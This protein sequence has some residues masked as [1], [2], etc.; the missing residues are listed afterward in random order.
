VCDAF[1]FT[2]LYFRLL[3][4]HSGTCVLVTQF[5]FRIPSSVN[6]RCNVKT[7]VSAPSIGIPLVMRT[8]TDDA[9]RRFRSCYD[10]LQYRVSRPDV[11]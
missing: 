9:L 11:C 5:V 6:D 10:A 8:V 3:K 7:H 1:L 2:L 4:C